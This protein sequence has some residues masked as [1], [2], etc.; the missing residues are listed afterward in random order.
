MGQSPFSCVS[1]LLAHPTSLRRQQEGDAEEVGGGRWRTQRGFDVSSA[2]KRPPGRGLWRRSPD[3]AGIM[4]TP[5]AA[6]PQA[7]GFR[8]AVSELDAKQAEAIMVRGRLVPVGRNEPEAQGCPLKVG[9]RLQAQGPHGRP[10]PRP[11]VQSWPQEP[12]LPG[13]CGQPLCPG[14]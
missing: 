9:G 13:L 10:G 7:K 1:V 14:V 6:S 11:G 8:R 12:P 4:P 2:Y 5:N 3:L